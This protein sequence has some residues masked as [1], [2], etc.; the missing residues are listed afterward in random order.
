MAIETYKT[1]IALILSRQDLPTLDRKIYAAAD[2]LC[3]GAYILSDAPNANPDLILIASGSEV[4]LIVRA[5]D[6][7]V[8]HNIAVRL[9]SMPSWELFEAQT[10][11]Y[12]NLVLP[13]HMHNRLV[14]EA[15]ISHGWHRYAGDAGDIIGID[16]FGASAPGDVMMREFGFT[17]EHVCYRALA[18]IKRNHHG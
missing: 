9:V 17:V 16:T 4:N 13:P 5:K 11:E 15:G 7:L 10:I 14:V 6:E 1:P 3:L 8:K 18:L 2:G 12:R